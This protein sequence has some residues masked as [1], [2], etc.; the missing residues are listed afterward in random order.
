MKKTNATLK[1]AVLVAGLSLELVSANAETTLNRST[2][3]GGGGAGSGGTFAVTC[4]IGQPIVGHSMA[5]AYSSDTGFWV[6]ETPGAP[7]L[8]ITR[9]GA[10]VLIT[11]PSASGYVLQ[12]TTD[13]RSNAAWT[14]VAQSPVLIGAQYQV[15]LPANQT[16]QF[17]RLVHQ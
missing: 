11:W 5:G 4:T 14:A 3:A 12:S 9:L 10:N 16:R 8:G 15:T 13:L 2:I 1:L 7:R 6:L 17:F